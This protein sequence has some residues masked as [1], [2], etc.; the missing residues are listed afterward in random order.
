[1]KICADDLSVSLERFSLKNITLEIK[2]KEIYAILGQTGSGKSVLLE[3]LAGF[4]EPS[5]G[6]VSYDD[7]NVC[8]IPIEDRN[9]GFV[10]QDN[11]LFPHMTVRR[12]IEFGLKMKKIRPD[13]RHRRSDELM[14][15]LGIA[16]LADRMPGN[17]SGGEQQRAAIARA[18]ITRPQ[19]LFMDEPFSAL[20]P[21]TKFRMYDLIRKLHDEF[22]CTIVF[23]THDFNEAEIMADRIGIILN[24]RLRAICGADQLH[25]LTL[26]NDV[27]E[28]L[29]GSTSAPGALKSY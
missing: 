20:D 18:L 4:Y 9:I 28:F 2:E 10:Y 5:S 24:G 25:D 6:S 8:D 16:H 23:V 29:N 14:R 27:S 22:A 7:T 17:L 3:S 21:N 13:E 1:M 19:I 26:D 11:G 15:E 12:N